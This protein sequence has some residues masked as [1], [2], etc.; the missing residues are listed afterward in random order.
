[1]AAAHLRI[2][3]QA[4]QRALNHLNQP[5]TSQP[6]AKEITMSRIS[7]IC[8]QPGVPV[9]LARTLPSAAAAPADLANPGGAACMSAGMCPAPAWLSFRRIVAIPFEACVA[10]VESWPRTGQDGEVRIGQ[11]RL[12]G[13]IKHDRDLGTCRIEAR[14]DRGPLRSLLRMRLDIDC[15][16]SSPSSTAFELIPCGRVRPTAAYFRAGHLLLDSLTHLLPQHVPPQHLAVSPQSGH[17]RI[18]ADPFRANGCQEQFSL[19]GRR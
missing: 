2:G 5:P 13:P 3:F 17:T 14:L 1:M 8:R 15:W 18:T 4:S 9:G 7:R 6:E 16:S 12:R 19:R 11:S 10:A